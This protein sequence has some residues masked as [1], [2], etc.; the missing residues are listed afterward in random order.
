VA[1]TLPRSGATLDFAA[2]R[3]RFP[4][5]ALAATLCAGVTL[6]AQAQA[7]N[8]HPPADETPA[9]VVPPKDLPA[10]QRGD[11]TRNLDRLFAALRAAPTAESAKYIEGRI[12][13]L[14]L[15]AGGDTATLL[16]SRAKIALD[17]K[18]YDLAIKLLTA[19]I[20]IK[21]D[22]TEA[23]NRR[24]TIHYMRKDFG[25]SL[26]DLFNVLEREP[27]HFAAWAGLGMI[28]QDIDEDKL[29]LYAF[30]RALELHPRLERIPDLVKKLTESVEGRD[31]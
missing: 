21:P 26:T 29:A 23:W 30:R 16:M 18:D 31:I 27:R 10:P 25:A 7:P 1:H 14:W 15:A 28:M 11:P 20:D 19:V 6:G 12:W 17:G 4:L 3:Y 13:A 22:Y 2:M 8:I 5:F 9:P 24:A